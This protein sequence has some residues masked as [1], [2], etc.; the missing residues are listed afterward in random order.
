MSTSDKER[1]MNKAV[2]FDFNGTMFFD[3]DKH[4]KSW[5]EYAY[6]KFGVKLKDEDFIYHIHGH[7]NDDILEFLTGRKFTLEE[8]LKCA[9]EKELYYQKL[10]EE[11]KENLHLV[12][13]LEDF[14]TL[15]KKNDIKIAIATAS[16]KP[17]VLWYIKTFD[18]YRFFDDS[19]I[20]YDDGTLSKGKPDPMIY[21]RALEAIKANKE[22]TIVFEDALSGIQSAYNAHVGMIVQV[23]DIR[24]KNQIGFQ[25]EC[26]YL[27]NDFTSLPDGIYEFLKIN[28][29]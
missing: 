9:E 16:M 17:N 2:I 12:T 7:S 15:L 4:I 28:T 3:E 25:P 29:K 21:N 24:R 26:K 13:G 20:I 10:C 27:I 8:T 22:D 19:N 23:D 18:L 6:Q 11:D 1:K 14:L 5:Y